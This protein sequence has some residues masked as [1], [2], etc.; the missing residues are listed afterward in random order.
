MSFQAYLDTIQKQT[1]KTPDEFI[2]MA[3]ERGFLQK[4][5]KAGD[6][7]A[8]LQQDFGLGRG[9]AMALYGLFKTVAEPER[10]DTGSRIDKVFSES[11][12]HWRPAYNA[13]L[14]KLRQLGPD[15]AVQPTDTY[16][17]FVRDGK[18]FAI[19]Q[20]TAKRL[21]I[22]IKLKDREPAGRFEPAGSWNSM[23]THRVKVS[24]AAEIDDE[25]HGWLE[26]AWTAAI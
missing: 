4:G 26:D 5:T 10:K 19:V 17:S 12:E 15:V 22:G 18:K 13:L 24:D 23:V 14:E 20:P 25:I 1:G 8:W 16:V 9:H 2:A 7:V 21:D 6:V 11:K 3:G